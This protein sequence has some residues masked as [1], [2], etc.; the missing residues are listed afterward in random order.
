MKIGISSPAF[1]L[2]PFDKTLEIVSK[3]FTLWEIVADIE[4]LLPKIVDDFK[5]LTP[6]YDMEYS[7]HAP[8]NDLNI[9]SLN[10]ELRKLALRYI[11]DAIKIA[12]ELEIGML[13]LHP[14]HLSPS[15]L[16]DKDTVYETNLRSIRE[17][18]NFARDYS[19]TI[20]L[21]NMPIRNWTLGN[22]ASEILDM[23]SDTQFGICFDVG[24]AFIQDEID[25]FLDVIDKI[26]HVHIH[27][28]NGRRDE[29]LI[30]C[31]GAID[32][33]S[34]IEKLKKEYSDMLI[35]E[36]N[37]LSEGI[38]SKGILEKMIQ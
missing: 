12:D 37:T 34:I 32:I 33:P 14:G 13:S 10:P 28:N 29:H 15:G 3:D 22:S 38:K 16:Y 4:Q 9:A 35:I 5:Q 26:Y 8:F 23:I 2:Q 19:I 1:T 31:E 27:D 21:E 24:H 36:S 17:I 6:S 20:A 7:I 18:A 25:G 30:L 11:K